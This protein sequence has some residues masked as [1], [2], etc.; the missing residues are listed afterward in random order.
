M[1][2]LLALTLTMITDQRLNFRNMVDGHGI[3]FV[4]F[5]QH[6]IL[7]KCTG[8]TLPPVLWTAAML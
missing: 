2:D 1:A 5:A 8:F 4:L 6:I 3:R 7:T